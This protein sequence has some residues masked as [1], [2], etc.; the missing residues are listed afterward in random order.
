MIIT[1]APTSVL[2]ACPS[3][4][5]TTAPSAYELLSLKLQIADVAATSNHF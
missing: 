5:G 3:H 2:H 1:E 4:V